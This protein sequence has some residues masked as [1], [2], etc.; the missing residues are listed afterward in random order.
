VFDLLMTNAHIIDGTGAG[1]YPADVGVSG[2]K[3]TA[4]AAGLQGDSLRK[5]DL[6]GRILAPGFID[7]HRHADAALFLPGFGKA[8]LFQGITTMIN[9]N[10][11][12]SAAP[13][14]P[15][16]R[17]EVLGYLSPVIGGLP[18]GVVFDSFSGY[19]GL[20]ER[21]PLALNAG[22]HIGSGTIRAAVGGYAEKALA[23]DAQKLLHRHLEDALAAGAFGVSV[24]FSYLPD[25]YYT[26]K[27][28][29][30]ALA[31]IRGTDI[32][33]VC[34]VRGEGGLLY[35]SVCEA[36]QT[37]RLLRVPLHISHFKCIGRRNWGGLLGKTIRLIEDARGQG[38]EITCDVYPWTAGSTQMACLLPPEFLQGGTARIVE[39][40]MDAKT[41]GRCREAMR[42]PS[43]KYEN[44][45]ES[46]GWES[47]YVSGIKTEKNRWSV[48]KS[49]VEI[50]N[51]R[52]VDP[53]DAAFDLLA[54]EGCNV[55]MVDYITCEEDIET[56]LH[57]DY[58][59]VISDTIYPGSG[60]PH[61]RGY[62]NTAMF[63]DTY[64]N[65]RGTLT[66]EQAIHKL[67][68][69]PAKTMRIQNKGQIRVGF[70]ADIVVIEKGGIRGTAD[71]QNPTRLSDGVYLAV[72]SGKIALENGELTG[73]V[74]GK[75]IRRG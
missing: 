51:I 27:A 37:A 45:V 71:Y 16:S 36:I 18:D 25:L 39:R 28:L 31:P 56:I 64:V 20:V 54:E 5:I 53:Y 15:H 41:R 23:K 72:I 38:L 3:I 50:A 73:D 9:G 40:L 11:G 67:T 34:H 14:A 7:I 62:G 74:S 58:S 10:C 2:G 60:L 24:G 4:I 44:I 6:C 66:L 13:L 49:I 12:M 46:M 35:E 8:E 52:K 61:P 1:A 26:P 68:A 55:T 42:T 33:L 47:I 69:L 48:G 22:S 43:L 29:A 30:G 59:S 32:P 17:Q 70:D 57:L 63:L 75:F 19:A 21:T 65:K